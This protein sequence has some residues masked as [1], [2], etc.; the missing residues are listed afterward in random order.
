MKTQA[1]LRYE[2]FCWD[3]FSV[4]LVGKLT[5]LYVLAVLLVG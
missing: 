4:V 1:E 2:R 3:Y 5:E